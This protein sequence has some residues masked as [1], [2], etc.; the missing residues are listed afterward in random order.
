MENS[1]LTVIGNL[2]KKIKETIINVKWKELIFWFRSFALEKNT[3]AQPISKETLPNLSLDSAYSTEL[4]VWAHPC[5]CKSFARRGR[6]SCK[7][8]QVM[9]I[10]PAFSPYQDPTWQK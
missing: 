8:R 1:S 4:S 6:R 5:F 10:S 9:A 7:P 2:C 3:D